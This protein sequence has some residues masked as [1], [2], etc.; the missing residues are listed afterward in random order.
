MS[1][2]RRN[3]LVFKCRLFLFF[4]QIIIRAYIF[5]YLGEILILLVYKGRNYKY[6]P[7]FVER[8]TRSIFI[9]YLQYF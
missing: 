2:K 1:R 7:R 5:L 6:S 8:I 3:A 4:N 9:H